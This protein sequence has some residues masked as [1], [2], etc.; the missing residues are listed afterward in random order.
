MYFDE[1]VVTK[2]S[3]KM[4]FNKKQRRV[5]A[6]SSREAAVSRALEHRPLRVAEISQ[7]TRI[8][9]M[10]IYSVLKTLMQRGLVEKNREGS[11]TLYRAK[12]L[13][14]VYM[15]LSPGGTLPQRHFG[16]LEKE[17]RLQASES[18]EFVL[19]RGTSSIV[20]MYERLCADH[21]GKRFRGIQPDSSVRALL[22]KLSLDDIERVNRSISKNKLIT[23]MI[24]ESTYFDTVRER[25]PSPVFERWARQFL[26]RLAVVY[27]VEQRYLSFRNEVVI[28]RD[29]V[30][31]VDWKE[32]SATEIKNPETVAMF[33]TLFEML[34][35]A[36]ERVEYRAMAK[37]FLGE[38]I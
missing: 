25:Y 21:K 30:Y 34:V 33:N 27:T 14:E 22:Q 31:I 15:L 7:K 17:V 20:N 26:N 11:R 23:E 18:T 4:R 29:T 9:R 32:E 28:F 10:T 12:S 2:Y 3:E 16:E 36:G 35:E 6:L 38:D 1:K 24:I 8:P 5:L 19:Y 37:K 13:R